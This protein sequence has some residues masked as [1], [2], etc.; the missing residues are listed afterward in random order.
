M[1]SKYTL[2]NDGNTGC[3]NGYQFQTQMKHRVEKIEGILTEYLPRQEGFQSVIMEAM[4]Y[5]LMAGGK[6]LRPMLMNETYRLFGGEGPLIRPFMA[7]IE[8]IHTYSLVHDDLPAMDN[9]EY[10][11]GRK[12]THIVYGE[13]MGILAGD[14]LL[15][16]AF[17]TAFKAFVMEP[18]ESLLIGRALGV[19]GEKAGIYGMIGGQVIDVKETGHSIP[20]EVLDTIYELKTSALIEASM[21][22]GAILGGASEEEVKIVE[23]IARYVGIAFQIQDDILDVTS[24]EEELG[25]PIHSDEKNHKTT[26]V[27]LM[28]IEKA[29]QQVKKL[30]DE[31]VTLLEGLNKKNEFLFTLVNELVG[32]RK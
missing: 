4:S 1:N 8:M 13:D 5:S 32:R 29:S 9:D 14:A 2:S 25:K 22:I 30:S 28:G 11:R 6:R 7:A 12:T 18:E 31:A 16:Y 15:N 27:T 17:E 23:K 24:T 21:M 20:K 26:Y 19:L 3:P 10:R